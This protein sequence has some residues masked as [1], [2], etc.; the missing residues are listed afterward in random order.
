M[1]EPDS[2][3]VDAVAR[4]ELDQA[5]LV[6]AERELLEFARKLTLQSHQIVADDL[7]RLRTVGWT[8]AQLAEAVYVVAMFAFF[9]RVADAFGLTDPQYR[10][11]GTNPGSRDSS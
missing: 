9:N 7:Q 1:Q 5:R 6:P 11:L 4:A 3:L 10:E 8:D 2:Q